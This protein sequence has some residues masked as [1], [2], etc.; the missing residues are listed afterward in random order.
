MR[1][2]KRGDSRTR[3]EAIAATWLREDGD[4]VIVQ[5]HLQPGARRT[6]AAGEYNGRLKVAVAA[7]PLEGRANKALCE[8]IAD[9]LDLP[10]RQVRILSG[11]RGRDKVLR[12]EGVD[13]GRAQRCL[14]PKQDRGGDCSAPD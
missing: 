3:I 13:A 4:A 14:A 5:I 11:E 7:A 9:R 12:I 10:V 1:E 8:W 2:G 6:G